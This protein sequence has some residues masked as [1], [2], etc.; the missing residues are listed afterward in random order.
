MNTLKDLLETS[1]RLHPKKTFLIFKGDEITYSDFD[2]QTSRLANG[3]QELGIRQG[4]RIGLFLPSHPN[5]VV[6]YFAIQKLG[7]VAVLLNYMLQQREVKHIVSNSGCSTLITDEHGEEIVSGLRAE[8][9]ELRNLVVIGH[10]R[11]STSI[12]YTDLL[13]RT[14]ESLQRVERSGDDETV[15]MY[16]SGTTGVPKGVVLTNWNLIYG[17]IIIIAMMGSNS[18][19]RWA[20]ALPLFNDF[21]LHSVILPTVY[22]GGTLAFIERFD[23]DEMLD[24]IRRHNAT[25]FA[26]VPTMYARMLDAYEHTKKA[27]ISLQACMTAAGT[28]SPD[29]IR[30]FEERFGVNVREGY[31]LTECRLVTG[32]S[33]Y[34]RAK[35]GSIGTP[36][37]GAIVRIIDEKGE[38]VPIGQHGECTVKS[39]GIFKGY[40]KMPEATAKI[41]RGGWLFTSDIVSQDEDGYLYFIDRQ[42][43][44]VVCGG[45][46]VYPKE[47]EDTLHSYPKVSLAGVVG[48]PD[49]EMGEIPIAFVVLKEGAVATDKE[50]MEFVRS[51]LAHYKAPRRI[52]FVTELPLGVGGKVLRRELRE[53]ARRD[54]SV[55]RNRS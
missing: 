26:G 45:A 5:L 29:V 9:P 11:L 44:L 13:Q 17:C 43:D 1:V 8:L 32:T 37:P 20:T 3:L 14:S 7:G 4:D 31:G 54:M 40:W 34:S 49:R 27:V 19:N 28:S 23:P 39:P 53:I 48:V 24:V 33:V 25:H 12:T 10:K 15:I 22:S 46:N 51:K 35:P 30:E 42:A 18:S 6:G 50:I 21:G 55:A 36:L 16:T 2:I 47:I 52:T 38:T 41:L